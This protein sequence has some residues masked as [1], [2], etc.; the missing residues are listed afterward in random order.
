MR[1]G[2]RV[3]VGVGVGVRV[4]VRN[5]VRVGLGFWP[6]AENT[7]PR[8][9]GH[10]AKLSSGKSYCARLKTPSMS[11]SMMFTPSITRTRGALVR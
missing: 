1:V 9:P 4:R 2:V 10:T 6:T 3:R 5:Q 7:V 8:E 11:A